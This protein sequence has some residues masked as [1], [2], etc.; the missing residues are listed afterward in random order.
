MTGASGNVGHSIRKH[1]ADFSGLELRLATRAKSPRNGDVYFDLEDIHSFSSALGNL[2]IL[3]LIRPPQLSNVKKYF[4]PL[5]KACVQNNVRHIIFLSVQGAD[6]SRAIPHRR[7]EEIIMSSG[8]PFTILRPS[9]FMQNL[10]TTLRDDIVKRDRIFLPA[11]NAPF[12]WVDVD[13]IGRSVR[14]IA[15]NAPAHYNKIYTITGAEHHTF[16]T[17]ANMLSETLER[18][19]RFENPNILRFV[20]EKKRQ[21]F[22]VAYIAVLILLH[23][24]ARF[25]PP[26][27][28]SDDF[29]KLTGQRP[30]TLRQFIQSSREYFVATS[31]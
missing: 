24:T 2:D 25:F 15:Q 31:R 8:I 28:V 9:Y 7:I 3:F 19:I 11:G 6:R 26:P 20:I 21:G 10:T 4:V 30:A 22:D 17:V 14:A 18:T 12:L 16:S 27:N 1:I 5:I 23:Y 13:D 29:F